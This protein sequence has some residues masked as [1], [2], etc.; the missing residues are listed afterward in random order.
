MN[1]A[2]KEQRAAQYHTETAEHGVVQFN[3]TQYTNI[4]KLQKS[5]YLITSV[6]DPVNS[7]MAAIKCAMLNW[8]AV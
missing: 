8:S 2:H 7:S 5:W 1:T 3:M 6:L 4:F